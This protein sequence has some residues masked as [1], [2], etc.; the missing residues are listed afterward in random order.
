MPDCEQM[1]HVCLHLD[2]VD[3]AIVADSEAIAVG[4]GHAVVR[5][6]SEVQSDVVDLSLNALLKVRRQS[7]EVAAY[8]I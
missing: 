8:A 3:D 2:S 4:T 7:E 5:K 6:C 1:N